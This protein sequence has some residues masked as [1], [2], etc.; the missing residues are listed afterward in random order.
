MSVNELVLIRNGC[1]RETFDLEVRTAKA[2]TLQHHL[3]N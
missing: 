2:A 1:S 3:L